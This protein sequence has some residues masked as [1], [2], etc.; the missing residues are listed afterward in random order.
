MTTVPA[1]PATAPRPTFDAVEPPLLY[2]PHLQEGQ[3]C[4]TGRREPRKKPTVM[5]STPS[6]RWIRLSSTVWYSCGRSPNT[7]GNEEA[8]DANEQVHHSQTA[9]H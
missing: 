7:S 3:V 2:V 4:A 1:T 5:P 6:D 9:D 8:Q